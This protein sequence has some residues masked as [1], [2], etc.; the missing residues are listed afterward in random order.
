MKLSNLILTFILALAVSFVHGQSNTTRQI[1]VN[2]DDKKTFIKYENGNLVELQIEGENIPKR[3]FNKYEDLLDKYNEDAPPV[4][5]FKDR[6]EENK[7]IDMGSILNKKLSQYLSDIDILNS[8]KYN[9]KLTQDYIKLNG[10]KLDS[11]IL[12]KC[13]AIFELTVGYELNSDSSFKAKITTNSR[14]IT[15]SIED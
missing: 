4:S 1:E 15:L 2:T 7:E 11:K 14:S 5:S 8:D 12:Y 6:K 13:L 9:I 10:K 3:D